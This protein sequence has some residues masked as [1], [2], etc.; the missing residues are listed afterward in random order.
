MNIIVAG[1]LS[2]TIVQARQEDREGASFEDAPIDHIQVI[3]SH[4]SYK[5]AIDPAIF[6]VMYKENPKMAQSLDYSHIPIREQLNRG[7]ANLEIDVY[8]DERGGKYAHPKGLE[9]EKGLESMIPYDPMHE[10]NAPGFKIFHVQELDFRS[11]YLTL[12][13]CL[14]DLRKWSD[15]HPGHQPVFITMEGKDQPIDRPGFNP[16]E[17]FSAATFDALD[18]AIIRSLGKDKLIAP[19]DIRRGEASLMEGIR[20]YG[21]PKLKQ[22]RGK[23]MFILDANAKKTAIYVQGHPALKGRILFANASPGSPESGMLIMNNAKTDLKQIRRLVKDGYMVRTRAD[24]NTWEA[25]N[26]DYSTFDA[27]CKSGAQ[28]ITT[29]YYQKSSHFPS[30]YQIH[31]DD[32]GFLR[33]NPLFND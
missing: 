29:D 23:F 13:A 32:G 8:A 22:A 1:V 31:F 17:P 5:T 28:I 20:K 2:G 19:D 12:E 27:A 30:N 16:P 3:G 14:E 15:E 33:R 7:L 24:A 9:L 25:R 21:W 18:Q 26:N 6:Q 4:N 10:M 11:Q